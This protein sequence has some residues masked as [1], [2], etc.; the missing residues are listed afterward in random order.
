MQGKPR[1]RHPDVRERCPAYRVVEEAR[2][3]F[4]VMRAAAVRMKSRARANEANE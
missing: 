2:Q 3:A 1:S 4:C